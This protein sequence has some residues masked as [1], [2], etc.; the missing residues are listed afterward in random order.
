[1]RE[2]KNS[3]LSKVKDLL[4]RLGEVKNV[5]VAY[6]SA[7]TINRIEA[8]L[9]TLEGMK[10][11][12]EEYKAF[13]K[14]VEEKRK[15]FINLKPNGEP[16]MVTKTL[17]NGQGIQVYDFTDLE[18][19]TKVYEK[20]EAEH[21]EAIKGMDNKLLNASEA[22]ELPTSIEFHYLEEKDIKGLDLT[23]SQFTAIQFLR[24]EPKL[25]LEEVP[26]DISQGDMMV[27]IEFFE[28]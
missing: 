8:E 15:K 27:L 21:S 4:A 10:E 17:N 7:K 23:A 1:M 12:T 16:R 14:A 2:I 13:E 11:K 6:A 3:D 25:K 5:K 22:R 19:W 20:L 28:L 18:G 24:K 9:K 26:G